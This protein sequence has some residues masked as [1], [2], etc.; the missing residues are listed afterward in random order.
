MIR[1]K[2][3]VPPIKVREK[4]NTLGHYVVFSGAPAVEAARLEGMT[5]ITCELI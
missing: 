4:L 2:I 1:A 3:D 5:A